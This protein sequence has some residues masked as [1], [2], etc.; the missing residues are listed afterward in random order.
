M[1]LRGL[2]VT[3]NAYFS[4]LTHTK[5]LLLVTLYDMTAGI[6]I[7]KKWDLAATVWTNRGEGLDSY[8]DIFFFI[9]LKLYDCV[10]PKN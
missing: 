10:D 2:V 5:Q 3:K 7:S 1:D 6:G 8:V 9:T 4:L